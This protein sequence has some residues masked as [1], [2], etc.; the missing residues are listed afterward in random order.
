MSEN[1]GV[2][3][4]QKKCVQEKYYHRETI[5]PNFGRFQRHMKLQHCKLHIFFPFKFAHKVEQTRS[6]YVTLKIQFFYRKVRVEHPHIKI[7]AIFKMHV[8]TVCIQSYN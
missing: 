1:R 2:S 3:M 5:L 8:T 7:P 6:L 4:A